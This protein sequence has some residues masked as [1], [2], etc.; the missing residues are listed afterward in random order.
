MIQSANICQTSPANPSLE[1]WGGVECT[2]NRVQDRY[3][4]QME[5]SGHA[6]RRSDYER[7]AGLGIRTVRV[8][9]LWER[10]ELDPSWRWADAHLACVRGSGMRPIVGL[11]H[12]GSGPPHTNLLDPEFPRKFAAYA[13]RVADRYPWVDCYTPIN[14]PNT[15][16][17]FSAMYGIWY[18]HA[19]SRAS[20]LRAL[21]NEVKATVLAMEEI[22]RVRPDAQ[23]I[24]TDDLGTIRG[25][26]ALRSTCELL[27]VR[28]WL[29]FDLLG[30]RV[31]RHHPMFVYMRAESIPEAEIHW[32]Q[33]HTCAPDIVGA[34]YYVTSDRYLDH[35][36]ALYPANCRSAEGPFVD[37]EAVRAHPEGITGIDSLLRLAW[38][39]YHVPVAITEVHLGCTV[40]QQIRWLAEIWEG[41]MR[42]RDAGVECV[43]LTVWALLGS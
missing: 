20:Y 12:H 23:L 34:N 3:F 27:N 4:D 7:F 35:R 26:G 10:H 21:L 32:F 19:M 6:D 30:G 17:R 37:V 1:T 43:A 28:Q 42:A 18:P 29:A 33:E 9:L 13:G 5:L 8:G 11:M 22:R 36:L 15:T 14:E 40:E 24:Q 38:N 2:C 39:R 16:A 41:A 25:T 31:D